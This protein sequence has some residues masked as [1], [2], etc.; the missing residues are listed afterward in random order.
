VV[1]L[2]L[3]DARLEATGLDDDRL[4]E[5]VARADTDVD[6]RSTST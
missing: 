4:A 5:P 2:V 3:D 6:R 1:H